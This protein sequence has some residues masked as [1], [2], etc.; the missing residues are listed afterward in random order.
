MTALE[1]IIVPSVSSSSRFLPRKWIL[2]PFGRVFETCP[3]RQRRNP[4]TVDIDDLHATTVAATGSTRQH[5]VRTKFAPTSKIIAEDCNGH[6]SNQNR[7][8]YP[9]AAEA[10]AA[11]EQ[12]PQVSDCS[13]TMVQRNS[14]SMKLTT[15]PC[16]RR[17]RPGKQYQIRI[18]G[19]WQKCALPFPG[20]R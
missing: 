1:P 11:P 13:M 8:V 14:E 3:R 6:P 2:R 19:V 9:M 16:S 10:A 7:E 5:E 18:L 17:W 12:L 4:G 20:K 15:R